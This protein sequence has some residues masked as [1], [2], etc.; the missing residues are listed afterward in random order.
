MNLLDL[1]SSAAHDNLMISHKNISIEFDGFKFQN[2]KKFKYLKLL[3]LTSILFS[4]LKFLN[5]VLKSPQISI[6]SVPQ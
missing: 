1:N 2:R 4:N 3:N 5:N 6:R